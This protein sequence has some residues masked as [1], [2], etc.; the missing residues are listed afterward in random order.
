MPPE[1]EASIIEVAGKWTIELA[2][3]FKPKKEESKQYLTETF[4]WA[5]DA[6]TAIVSRK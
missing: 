3:A 6:L 5:Y 1:V 2:E 4:Q